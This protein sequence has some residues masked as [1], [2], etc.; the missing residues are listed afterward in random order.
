MFK[1]LKRIT[2]QID[3]SRLIILVALCFTLFYNFRFFRNSAAIYAHD[4]GGVL[5]VASLA[6]FLFAL[7]VL[8]LAILCFRFIV[9]PALALI[10]IGAAAANYYMN[11]FNVVIDTTMITNMMRTDRREV[12]DLMSVQLT[13]QILLL[14]VLPSWLVYKTTIKFPSFMLTLLQRLKLIGIAFVMVLVSI[15]PFTP[16]YTSFFRE[17]KMLRYYA[18]PVTFIYSSVRIVDMALASVENL[19]RTPIGLDAHN[20]AS[21]SQRQ[22]VIL[23][24]GEAARADRF[25]L[26]GYPRATNIL[27]AEAGVTSFKNVYSCGT[28]TAYSLPCMFSLSDRTD[29]DLDTANQTENA[30]DVLTHAGV[31]VLWRDNNSDAKGVAEEIAFE[32]FRS[33]DVNNV[34]DIECRDIGMLNGLPDYIEQHPTGDIVIVLHQM[35][36]HGPDYYKRYPSNFEIY[37]PV[38]KTNQLENCTDE[39][40]SNAYDNAVSYTDFFLSQLIVFLKN[41]DNRF[42]TVMYYMGDHGESLGENGLYLHGLPYVL[43]PDIQKHVASIIWFGANYPIDQNLIREKVDA[44]ISHDSYFHTILGLLHIETSVYD[45]NK[46]FLNPALHLQ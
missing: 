27:L 23:V 1:N 6:L 9:K 38:C 2:L 46:D 45:P 21:D 20:A 13:I 40:L 29:F 35:G 44:E 28:S 31:N 16:Y 41:Y 42:G 12:A 10:F 14:G 17:N 30:L 4:I 24:V 34:C 7:T 39:E 32:D 33:A 18:N 15:A 8:V 37:T 3:C 11:T 36:M 25:S 19:V 43:A 26:N 22:L 5:F